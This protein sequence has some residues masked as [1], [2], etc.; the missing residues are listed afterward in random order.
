MTEQDYINV[1]EKYLEEPVKSKM[2]E[3]INLFFD[4]TNK[5]LKN[6]NY[7][8]GEKNDTFAI[9]TEKLQLA[10]SRAKS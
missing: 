1:C 9:L 7:E 6:E 3:Q 4:L 5:N 10:T 8:V 2:I